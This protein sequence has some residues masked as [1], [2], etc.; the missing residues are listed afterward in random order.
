MDTPLLFACPVLQVGAYGCCNQVGQST[1]SAALLDRGIN[2]NPPKA[3]IAI[4]PQ[5]E[6]PFRASP[7]GI[8]GGVLAACGQIGAGELF[9]LARFRPW[10]RDQ[11]GLSRRDRRA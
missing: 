7:Q 4:P 9:E 5:G 11:K 6:R 1:G 3:A 8:G 2:D 10:T